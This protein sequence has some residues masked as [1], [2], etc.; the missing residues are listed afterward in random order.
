MPGLFVILIP[1]LASDIVNPVLLAAVVYAFGS[2]RPYS[3]ALSILL[4]WF[5]VYFASGV[6]LTIAL[7]A[8]T[9]YLKNPRPINFAI[10]AALG[11]VLIGVGIQAARG[12]DPRR[13]K[14]ELDD[15]DSLTP[16]SG[17]LARTRL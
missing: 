4:G 15:A 11:L 1:I 13:K 6:V 5:V 14:K 16:I 17:F 3:N 9:S 7:E 10:E 2:R 8:I 12:T